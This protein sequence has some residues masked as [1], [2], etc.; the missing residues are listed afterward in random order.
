MKKLTSILVCL[1]LILCLVGCGGEVDPPV[2]E[3]TDA[4][5]IRVDSGSVK[6][7]D[8]VT[9]YIE[10]N[11]VKG[12]KSIG[13][14]PSFDAESFTL[15]D[16]RMLVGD[17]L[18]DFSNGIGTAINSEA[19]DYTGVRVFEFVL[20]AKAAGTKKINCT[21]SFLGDADRVIEVNQPAA[22]SVTVSVP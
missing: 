21:V 4:I 6:I 20:K 16:G 5:S 10:V 8:E 2:S 13:L 12:V 1:T 7:G 3:N 9:V 15:V 19:K 11:E 18:K 17:V 22:A 14:R